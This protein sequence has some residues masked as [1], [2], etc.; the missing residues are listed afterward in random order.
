MIFTL[1][2]MESDNMSPDPLPVS[3][4]KL[5]V[6]VVVGIIPKLTRFRLCDKVLPE[7][8]EVGIG[9]SRTGGSSLK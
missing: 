3:I 2:S 5:S 1:T 8:K 9:D 4:A 6:L 7:V